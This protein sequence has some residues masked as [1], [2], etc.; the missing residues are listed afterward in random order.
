MSLWACECVAHSDPVMCD[1][2][3]IT[4]ATGMLGSQVHRQQYSLVVGLAGFPGISVPAAASPLFG[5]VTQVV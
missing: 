4:E 1:S 3:S 5:L 2:L